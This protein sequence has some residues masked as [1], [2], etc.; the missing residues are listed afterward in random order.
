VENTMTATRP[1]VGKVAAVALTGVLLVFALLEAAIVLPPALTTGI[2]VTW[3]MDFRAYMVHTERWLAG[4]GFYLP[5][6]LAG[7]P[8]SD[9]ALRLRAAVGGVVD[10]AARH[11]RG[12]CGPF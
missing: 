1:D 3:G 8:V 5:E 4:G 6:Q 2:D 9:R 11:H 12:R 10:R 7:A